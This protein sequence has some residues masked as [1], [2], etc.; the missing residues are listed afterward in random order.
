MRTIFGAF[1]AVIVG[2]QGVRHEIGQ[3]PFID[4]T[5]MGTTHLVGCGEAGRA[6]PLSPEIPVDIVTGT[7]LFGAESVLGWVDGSGYPMTIRQ[8]VENW[9]SA[10]TIS[11]VTTDNRLHVYELEAVARLGTFIRGLTSLYGQSGI[12]VQAFIPLYEYEAYGLSLYARGVLS[13]KLYAQ[14]RRAVRRRAW[15]ISRMLRGR[16]RGTAEV[17]AGS[18]LSLIRRL[19]I[20]RVPPAGLP[21]LVH[22]ALRRQDPLWRDLLTGTDPS[23]ETIINA[24]YVYAYLAAVRTARRQRR[25]VV[26]VED[27]DE[28][29]ISRHALKA[30]GRTGISM[31]GTIAFYV[32]PRVVVTRLAPSGAA[33]DLR[34][35]A[36]G[37]DRH[38]IAI[39]MNAYPGG[40][41]RQEMA[42]ARWLQ[43]FEQAR[44]MARGLPAA[45]HTLGRRIPAPGAT[46]PR[47]HQPGTA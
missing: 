8:V 38:T 27:P 13:A 23:F 19:D 42:L 45:R 25:Q 10:A 14:Y 3:L 41:R 32:H 17:T 20:S 44:Q 18:P 31:D 21:Q 2:D 7:C 47:R 36:N 11:R 15:L 22:D 35:C 4:L 24:G 40:A 33:Y 16:L 37:A 46:G 43:F 6:V 30:S 34:Q 5:M 1:P 29:P 28:E 9:D 26:L 39:A 12:R